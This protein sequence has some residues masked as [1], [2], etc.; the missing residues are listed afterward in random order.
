[1]T[2]PGG[3]G[4]RGWAAPRTSARRAA[5]TPFLPKAFSW[6]KPTSP[7]RGALAGAAL[8]GGSP[9]P[10]LRRAPRFL[11]R[12]YFCV[13]LRAGRFDIQRNPFMLLTTKYSM[14]SPPDGTQLHQLRLRKKGGCVQYVRKTAGRY[15]QGEIRFF[16]V[17]CQIKCKLCQIK[18]NLQAASS[19][20][21]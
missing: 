21:R 19:D 18:C 17:F 4:N 2:E 7:C 13:A 8:L 5:Q 6:V 10:G 1:V 3:R 14:Q 16:F 15:P 9:H 20:A 11:T 12:G